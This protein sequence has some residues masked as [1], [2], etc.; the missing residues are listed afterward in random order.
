VIQNVISFVGLFVLILVAWVISEDRRRFPWRVV[1]WGLTLQILFGFLVLRWEPGARFFLGLNDVFNALLAF[2]REGAVFVFNSVGTS[3][4]GGGVI[5]LKD[6][7]TRLGAESHDPIIQAA[8]RSG[9]VPGAF[10]AFQ[11]LT[12]IIFFSALLS[13]LYYLG[14]MQKI[15]VLFAKIMA[16]TMGVSGAESLSNSANI[17]VG[18]T[19]APL[20]VRPYIEKMTRSELMAIMVGGFAN[21]AGGV[22]G[23]YVMMLS[24]YFP[25]I[26]SHL[27]AASLLS[28]PAAF[29]FAKVMVPEKEQPMTGGDMKMEVE[30]QDANLIDAASSGTTV[31]WQLAINVGAMLISFVALVAMANLGFSWFGDFFRNGHGLVLFDLM[32]V[33]AIASLLFVEKKG[34]TSD[35]LMWGLLGGLFALVLALKLLDTGEWPRAMTLVGMAAWL[36]IFLLSGRDK[37]Y[38]RWGWGGVAATALV[39]NLAYFLVG[40]LAPGTT[41]SLQVVLGWLH[42]PVAF[43]MGVPAQDCMVVGKLLGEKLVLTEFAAYI[44]L[45]GLLGASSRGEIPPIDPRSTVIVSYALCGFANIASI[46]IQIGGIAPLAPSRRHDIARLGFKAMVGGALATFMIA[47]VAGMFYHG[48]DTLGIPGAH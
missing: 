32:A 2:S 45:A 12:T 48:V 22:L 40:P 1:T 17:F 11:V 4:S 29:I 10:F 20:V 14:V 33:S 23:A 19:E 42:W 5:S 8:V 21:T 41:L 43:V 6:Y 46:G 35:V 7:L 9:A 28:A 34:P 37:G 25:N 27:I 31:G 39:A 18:Q 26:A 30:I 36:P 44:D 3:E 24:G 47:C 15:V 16:H 38:G 13:V